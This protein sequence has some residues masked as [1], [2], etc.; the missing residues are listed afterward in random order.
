MKTDRRGRWARRFVFLGITLAVACGTPTDPRPVATPTP[1]ATPQVG[2][3]QLSRF[4]AT[5]S[6]ITEGEEFTLAWEGTSGVVSI[7]KTGGAPFL[8]SRPPTGSYV[9]RTGV[10]GYPTGTG[11]TTYEAANSDVGQR[12]HATVT[13]NPRPAANHDP[14]VTVAATPTGCHPRHWTPT[15][16]S[17]TCTATASDP[18]GD[19]LSY[20]WSGCATGS[21]STATCTISEPGGFPCTVTV[22]DGKGGS[23]TGSRTVEGTNAAPAQTSGCWN[24]GYGCNAT[25]LWAWTAS[26]GEYRFLGEDSDDPE[27]WSSLTCSAVSQ[28]PSNCTVRRCYLYNAASVRFFVEFDTRGPGTC[29]LAVTVTDDWGATTTANPSIPVI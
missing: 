29:M 27:P 3:T 10:D 22:T 17:V 8:L 12:L 7:S 15:S 16:C 1:T 26:A 13:V 9:L 20:R 19:A 18:D 4:T 6:T 14:T 5:P 28:T 11:Q 21:A 2:T 24:A 23:A 25:E